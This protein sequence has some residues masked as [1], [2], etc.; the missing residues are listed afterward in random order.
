MCGDLTTQS[1]VI[2]ASKR[3]LRLRPEPKLVQ[4][5]FD[6]HYHE[7]TENKLLLKEQ[8]MKA[9]TNIGFELWFSVFNVFFF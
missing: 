8:Q 9:N 1:G 6:Q 3:G 2:K 7:N 4:S 5:F